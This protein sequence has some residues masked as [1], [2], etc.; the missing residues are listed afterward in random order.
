LSRLLVAACLA[1]GC[2]LLD[3]DV[4]VQC[5]KGCRTPVSFTF[6]KPLEPGEYE[7]V[8]SFD[9]VTRRCTRESDGGW[10]RDPDDDDPETGGK[11]WCS[12]EGI[13]L[14]WE[15]PKSIR[16]Q[17]TSDETPLIDE[18]YEPHYE[19]YVI[20]CNGDRCKHADVDVAIP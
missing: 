1:S 13:E 4:Q 3:D 17:I 7:Y 12:L 5:G 15:E 8:V 14:S 9:G 6:S 16:L 20:E 18:V 2:S 19:T 10:H 11:I